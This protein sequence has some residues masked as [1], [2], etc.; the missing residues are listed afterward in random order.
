MPTKWD[1]FAKAIKN[2]SFKDWQ[3]T[4]SYRQTKIPLQSSSTNHF[5]IGRSSLDHY[6]P[7]NN[8][9]TDGQEDAETH[10]YVKE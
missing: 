1:L 2:G 5:T 4:N 8:G 7:S 10:G 3:H 9:Y 6:L